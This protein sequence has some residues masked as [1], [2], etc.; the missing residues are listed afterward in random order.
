MGVVAHDWEGSP[1]KV[2]QD[3]LE[4]VYLNSDRDL[5]EWDLDVSAAG[6]P[7]ASFEVYF[8]LHNQTNGHGWLF[9]EST[10][11]RC[12]R[13]MIVHS[14]SLGGGRPTPSPCQENWMSEQAKMGGWNHIITF[15]SA[16]TS[17]VVL[18]GVRTDLHS[19]AQEDSSSSA[20]RLGAPFGGYYTHVTVA[21]ARVYARELRFEEIAENALELSGETWQLWREDWDC[22]GDETSF[23]ESYGDSAHVCAAFCTY[24]N[25]YAY[26][27]NEDSRQSVCRCYHRCEGDALS[28]SKNEVYGKSAYCRA[29]AALGMQ[30]GDIQDDQISAS[31]THADCVGP[32]AARLY[33][34]LDNDGSYYDYGGSKGA[35]CPNDVEIGEWLQVD[36]GGIRAVSGVAM[37]GAADAVEWV[38]SYTVSVAQTLEDE[39]W[40]EVR[41][42]TDSSRFA[43]NTDQHSV[44]I[45]RFAA[46]VEARYIRVYPQTY[47]SWN[48][49]RLELYGSRCPVVEPLDY[50]EYEEPPP[51]PP[52]AEP[53]VLTLVG[54]AHVEVLQHQTYI[55]A[56]ATAVDLVDG[57]TPIT[58]LGL[59]DVATSAIT[60]HDAPF[61]IRYLAEDAAGN[62]AVPGLERKGWSMPTSNTM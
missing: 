56:G 44:V 5:F 8:Y 42:E 55:D 7:K 35:W 33:H 24:H 53:P 4:G 54:D 49:M 2:T 41:S 6:M 62:Q 26:W 47:H 39:V 10:R 16:D 23:V 43:G 29:T 27:A 38:T 14:E 25:F 46:V 11:H 20:L 9:G 21:A 34:I 31:S 1:Q 13:Y 37:Q 52:D 28:G 59:E 12:R 51:P 40:I 3:L 18:N 15:H 61:V 50:S 36:L 32:A 58:P 17:Y 22:M 19:V 30:N 48:S 45:Q 60:T 57:V